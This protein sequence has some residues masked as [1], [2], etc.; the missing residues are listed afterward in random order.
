MIGRAGGLTQVAT[1]RSSVMTAPFTR[2]FADVSEILMF[3]KD[4]CLVT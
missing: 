1:R 3:E 2:F 4:W